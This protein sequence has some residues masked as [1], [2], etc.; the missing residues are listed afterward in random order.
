MSTLRKRLFEAL[1]DP[2]VAEL[3]KNPRI[4]AAVI[5]A[6]RIRGRVE[7][8]MDRQ[9]QAIAH[10][11]NLATQKDLRATHRRI[12]EL[13]RELRDAEQRLTVA[14]VDREAQGRS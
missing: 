4:Q 9:L 5:R 10:R 2:R 1:Q 11:L 13:E 3:M 12:R 8:A 6:F 14:E 7:G